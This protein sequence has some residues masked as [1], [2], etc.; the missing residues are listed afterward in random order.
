MA[1][2]KVSVIVATYNRAAYLRLALACLGRQDFHGDWEIVVADDGSTDDTEQVIHA[3]SQRLAEPKVWHCWHEHEAYRRA[4]SL[5]EAVRRRASGD[6]LIFLDGDCLPALDLVRTYCS[7]RAPVGFYLGGIYGLNREFSE[8][9]LSGGENGDAEATI[10]EAAKEE[11][12]RKGA[13]KKVARRY[14]KSRIYT[15]LGFRKPKIWGANFAVNRD[16]FEAVNGFDENYVGYGQE[17]SDLRDRL[18]KGGYSPVC[19]HT[20]TRAYHLWH[21]AD[22]A[23]RREALGERNNRPYY[24][25]AH[26]EIVCRNGLRKL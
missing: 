5:N 12:Q 18:L 25:R 7:H 20:K 22:L 8:K 19:L 14:W 23:A 3:L 2:T 13:K 17:D 21:T 15:A 16:V 26:V 10:A 1:N 4:F 24:N 9:V 11:N 6:L